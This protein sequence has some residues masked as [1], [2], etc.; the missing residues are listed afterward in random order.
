L[1]EGLGGGIKPFILFSTENLNY[2]GITE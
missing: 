1:W 2:W